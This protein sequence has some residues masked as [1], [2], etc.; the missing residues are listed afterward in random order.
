MLSP[1]EVR[2]RRRPIAAHPLRYEGAT[3][4]TI[5]DFRTSRRASGAHK[6]RL[7]DR[8]A[9]VP[10]RGPAARE[11]LAAMQDFI[12]VRVES[13]AF[14]TDTV[15]VA[16]LTGK[17][18]ISRLF[19]LELRLVT[20]E[21]NIDEDGLLTNPMTLVF[22]RRTAE[23]AS[24]VEERRISGM[25]RALVDRALSESR[26]RE[27]LCTFVP[28]AWQ[29]SL[30]ITS[31]VCQDMTTPD[32]IK[33]KIA[34]GASLDGGI[35]VEMRTTQTYPS[36]EFVVQYKESNLDFACRLAE[37]LGIFFFFEEKDGK[38]LIVFADVNASVKPAAPDKTP[39]SPRGE[40]VSV[41]RLEAHRQ[42]VSQDFVA[43]DYN[44]RNPSMDIEGEAQASVL[45]SGRVDEYGPHA[46]TP[47]EAGFYA[48]VRAEEAG[49]RSLTYEGHSDLPG[50][51]AGSVVTV[52]G[53]P[54]GDLE[55][56]VVSVSHEITQA[57]FGQPPPRE[58]PY[59]N[60]FSAVEKATQYRP[61]RLTPRPVVNSVIT[62]IVESGSPTDFGAIDDQGR[63]RVAFMYDAVS[64]RAAGKASRPLRMA[65]P[66]AAS[67]R[68]FHV[69]LKPGTEVIISCVNG[70]PDRPIIAGAVPN[71]QT[72]SPVTSAI[73]HKSI[74]TTNQNSIAIDDQSPRCKIS[75]S[76]ENHIIQLG[77]PESAE[78]GILIGTVD[79]H[80]EVTTAEKTET[81]ENKSIY[82]EEL[83][84]LAEKDILECAGIP[85]PMGKW[86]K[87]ASTLSSVAGFVKGAAEFG[88]KALK[89]Y[90][91]HVSHAKKEKEDADK[92]LKKTTDE[93]KKTLGIDENTKPLIITDPKTGASRHE[94]KDEAQNRA[95]QTAL[96]DPKNKQQ[97]E[98]MKTAGDKA[99]ESGDAYRELTEKTEKETKVGEGIA[100]GAEIAKTVGEKL[101]HAPETISSI[102]ETVN[103]V[104]EKIG[105]L[106]S[107]EEKLAKLPVTGKLFS[108]I[109]KVVHKAAHEAFDAT[110]DTSQKLSKTIPKAAHER[111]QANTGSFGKP[112]N[113]QLSRHSASLYA[114]KNAF[115]FGGL[116]TTM[117]S[118]KS[119]NIIGTS[120]VDIKSK[121]IVEIATKHLMLTGNDQ[122]DAHASKTLKLVAHD[123]D[124]SIAVPGGNSMYFHAKEGL[125]M[126]SV[127]KDITAKAKK[128]V[129]V[130]A[131]EENI[132]LTTKK[133]FKLTAQ[134]NDVN[135]TAAKGKI[136]I[137][138]SKGEIA[139]RAHTKAL[140]QSTDGDFT[141]VSD[142]GK[143]TVKASKELNLESKSGQ[144]KTSGN[145]EFKL[146]KFVVTGSKIELG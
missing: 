81:S 73:S 113:I 118:G 106:K 119:A 134:E 87:A 22:E 18:T 33:K 93:V 71:P 13:S 32:I 72:P 78:R 127:E 80:T 60:H 82:T 70:D 37:D 114:A 30:W 59:R 90:A 12:Q 66:S 121:S 89:M 20:M 131:E 35:D 95:L 117:F 144:W 41:W 126:D 130:T 111:S 139:M 88:D 97:L 64:D 100:K 105:V 69:P 135:I 129:K 101:E 57:V 4:G 79:N 19:E 10:Y 145:I 1:R 61:P 14:A 136:E 140:V 77:E 2:A 7:W 39:Y 48:R 115:I 83:T 43:R 47:A 53:H 45:S 6:R 67:D 11:R 46:K 9:S 92:D 103:K 56:V 52:E 102:A 5:F 137:G 138:A 91:E 34:E 96:D 50:L 21:P 112:Y 24:P 49:T 36:R 65:Q 38:D 107:I 68:G 62:G 142:K 76:V 146:K 98:K 15:L 84:V 143:G 44:Y 51:R 74:W 16:E 125:I 124:K 120:R 104:T 42:L 28:R 31:D 29:A 128:N 132:E 27:Y 75:V 58:R 141:V 23:G 26:H 86:A 116:S 8:C 85:N 17:E 3:R 110:V 109:S 25:V 63:Y 40:N 108:V 123:G 99:I 122:I 94:T 55:L 54:R 133:T